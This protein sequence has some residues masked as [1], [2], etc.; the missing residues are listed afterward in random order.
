MKSKYNFQVKYNPAIIIEE[1]SL[2]RLPEIINSGAYFPLPRRFIL[3]VDRAFHDANG[4]LLGK[5]VKDIK[6]EALIWPFESGENAKSLPGLMKILDFCSK[7]SIKRDDAIGVIG[8]GTLCDMI[9]F[10]ASVYLRGIHMINIP[11]TLISCVDPVFGKAAINH[12][13]GEN[14]I[15]S[16][17]VPDLSPIDV[18]FL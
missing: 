15:G 18:S 7:N 6:S 4:D 17:S 9:A 1:G 11:T 2:L 16:Y 10:A 12:G 3:V 13:G 14:L 8:G 5:F